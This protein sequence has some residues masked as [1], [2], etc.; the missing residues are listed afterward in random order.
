[1]LTD[2]VLLMWNFWNNCNFFD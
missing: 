1:M 2:D